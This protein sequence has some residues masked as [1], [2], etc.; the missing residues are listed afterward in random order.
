MNKPF[1]AFRLEDRKNKSGTF[2]ED[3]LI[4]I[5]NLQTL[6]AVAKEWWRESTRLKLIF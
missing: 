2:E 6:T 5:Q 3:T 4:E 1:A